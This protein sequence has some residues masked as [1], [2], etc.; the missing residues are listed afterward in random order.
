MEQDEFNKPIDIFFDEWKYNWD[1]IKIKI[2]KFQEAEEIKRD[3]SIYWVFNGIIESDKNKLRINNG[4]ICRFWF[5]K[6]LF[7][8]EIQRHLCLHTF[9]WG[10]PFD[11]MLEIKR[12]GK[13]SLMMKNVDMSLSSTL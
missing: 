5:S 12:T 9:Q 13:Y 2:I 7:K 4:S 10:E 1:W 3:K 6:I 11:V 8:R